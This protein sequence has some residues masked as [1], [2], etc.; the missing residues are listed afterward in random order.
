[1]YSAL[2]EFYD[3]LMTDFDYDNYLAFLK[4]RLS[5]KRGLDLACGSGEMTLRLKKSGYDMTGAD[6]SSEMLG[7]AAEKS[8]KQH[9]NVRF[10]DIDL[11][12][13]EIA[14]KYDFITAVCDGF[15]Y[16]ESENNF[17]KAVRAVYN[18]LCDGGSFVFD[19]ST[20]SKLTD[21]LGNN[22]FYEDGDEL[23]YFWKNSD[24]GNRV[25]MDLT[26][27]KLSDN[28]LYER[29][30][31]SQTQY[32]Y[33]ADTVESILKECGF[34]YDFYNEFF[35]PYNDGASRLIVHAVK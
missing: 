8:R 13:V 3:K 22:V 29:S 19:L 25:D 18:A 16:I 31:E 11:N 10:I 27:F 24:K 26:F 23:S 15:N 17:K 4:K 6:V 33:S 28:G 12:D 1:M 7:I 32:K 21:T 9:L 20:Y 34:K 2:S 5:G 14:G 35:N 30:D